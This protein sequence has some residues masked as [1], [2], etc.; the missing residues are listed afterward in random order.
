MVYNDSSTTGQGMYLENQNATGDVLF[1]F[2]SP[3]VDWSIGIDRGTNEFKATFGSDLTGEDGIVIDTSGNVS[4]GTQSMTGA[5]LTVYG[6]MAFH[7][8]ADGPTVPN[9]YGTVWVKNTTPTTLWFTDESDGDWQL[10]TFSGGGGGVAATPTPAANEIAIW[11]STG[12]TIKGEPTFTRDATLFTHEYT[13]VDLASITEGFLL[14]D[15]GATG[16][17][18]MMLAGG[19]TY[20]IGIAVVKALDTFRIVPGPSLDVETGFM[21]DPDG[22]MSINTQPNTNFP[23]TLSSALLIYE[24]TSASFTPV[25]SNFGAIW[26]KNT[27]PN[28]LWFTD[29][30]DN[31][32]QLG[33]SSGGGGTI[34]GSIAVNQ[35]A[36]GS[37]TNTIDGSADLTWNDAI[38]DV[39]FTSSGTTGIGLKLENTSTGDVPI[40]FTNNTLSWT[41]GIDATNDKFSI[42]EGTALG[43]SEF[44]ILSTGTNYVGIQTDSPNEQLTIGGTD[45]AISIIQ[46]SE[47]GVSAGYGK[48]W[49]FDGDNANT[50]IWFRN[51]ETT[52]GWT[53]TYPLGRHWYGDIGAELDNNYSG[54]T[55]DF[56][57]GESITSMTFGDVVRLDPT[58]P[59]EVLRANAGDASPFYPVI[60][61]YVGTAT[62]TAGSR[63]VFLLQGFVCDTG[64]GSPTL[65]RQVYLS[66]SDGSISASPPTVAGDFVQVLGLGTEA[67]TYHS[68]YFNPSMDF[69][70]LT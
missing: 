67:G 9:S 65:G 35:L 45:A 1:N 26:V 54:V 38:L 11:D 61:M 43:T 22:N 25:P 60:A 42:T 57:N 66:T 21:M 36:V 10:G 34:G 29:E 2:K 7:E 6:S 12:A 56:I 64:F 39:A 52:S 53:T 49:V 48:L 50:E 68:I 59:N 51:D 28:T 8:V 70:E 14:K 62:L 4:I 15:V 33:T 44:C 24:G 69:I 18:K 37:G 30:N 5:R 27:T 31:D 17:P 32:F 20:S 13:A 23:L 16:S 3:I 63:G 41:M 47:P 58:T 46:D 40:L 19:E 55:A